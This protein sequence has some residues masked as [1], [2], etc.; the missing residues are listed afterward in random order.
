M[1][2]T[3]HNGNC[4]DGPHIE[5]DTAHAKNVGLR[6]AVPVVLLTMSLW[7]LPASALAIDVGDQAP[8]FVMHS[9]VGETVRLSEYQGRKTVLMFFFPAAFTSV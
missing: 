8:D 2:V 3:S 1:R 4:G 5:G 9:T 7:L 6:I